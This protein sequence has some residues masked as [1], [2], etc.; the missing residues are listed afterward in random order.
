M[1][2][3]SVWHE[4]DRRDFGTQI[5]GLGQAQSDHFTV[6]SVNIQ[7]PADPSGIMLA[8]AAAIVAGLLSGSTA[9]FFAA[10]LRPMQALRELG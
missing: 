3:R 4:R 8:V 1:A 7:A 5:I 6:A 10:R 9:A 2:Q